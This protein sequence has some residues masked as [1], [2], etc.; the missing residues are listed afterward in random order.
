M[1]RQERLEKRRR[2]RRERR[3]DRQELIRLAFEEYE[4]GDDTE[5]VREALIER[6]D[7]EHAGS[8]RGERLKAFLELFLPLLMKLLVGI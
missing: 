5:S 8:G 6:I 1:N 7:A 2:E 4:E 3:E